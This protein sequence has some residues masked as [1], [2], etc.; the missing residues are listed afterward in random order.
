MSVWFKSEAKI[1][2]LKKANTD[3]SIMGLREAVE[4]HRKDLRALS[5][6]TNRLDKT[7]SIEAERLRQHSIEANKLVQ[8]VEAF[9]MQADRQIR[10]FRYA[11]D[12]GEVVKIGQDRYMFRALRRTE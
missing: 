9:I 5:D 12:N 8:R 4:E 6:I 2:E 10:D 11:L 7:M 3:A 1:E